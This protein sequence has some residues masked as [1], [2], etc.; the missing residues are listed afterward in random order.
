M[1][2]IKI[3]NDP[4]YGFVSLQPEALKIIDHIYFQRLRQIKQ[5]G[6]THL[7]YPG[8]LHTRFHH[9]IGAY[10]L[11]TLAISNLR[12]KQNDISEKEALACSLA[13]LLHDIGHGP[14]SHALE[15]VL[16]E[17]MHHEDLSLTFMHF[18]NNEFDGL[19]DEAIKIFT[20][21]HP[22]KFL[23]Q[24]VSSQ[25]DVDRLDYL[26]RDSFYTGVLEGRIGAERIIKMLDVH[27]NQIVI[28][29]KGIYSVEQFLNA[30]RIMYWQVYLHKTVIAAEQLFLK[31][32][33]RAK[34]LVAMGHQL[35]ATH[36][37]KTILY[38]SIKY[39]DI[40]FDNKLLHSFALIDDN[41]IMCSVK[42]WQY[43][44][45]EILAFLCQSLIK[46]NLPKVELYNSKDE[47]F[48]KKQ[49]WVED[50][51]EPKVQNKF[52]SISKEEIREYFVSTDKVK[53]LAYNNKIDQIKLYL[54]DGETSDMSLLSEWY[55]RQTLSSEEVKYFIFYPNLNK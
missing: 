2:K 36:G 40:Q 27:N 16:I 20:K 37:F 6:L 55:S 11:S 7:V 26:Q 14:F 46:R 53:N 22:K 8:A 52:K 48:I 18:L 47:D 42:E 54:K 3:I 38:E 4:V 23:S 15:Q 44:N 10:H 25:L 50:N 17:N 51:V 24:L 1:P 31:I 41:D 43:N 28:E 13:T 49:Q 29:A 33:K 5:L 19:L 32:M 21:E 39:S 9:A 34:H 35:F 45:D 12:L 30:R